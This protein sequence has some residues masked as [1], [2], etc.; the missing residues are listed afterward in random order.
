MNL[1]RTTVLLA[2]TVSTLACHDAG[3]PPVPPVTFTLDNING[4]SLPY[5]PA[6]PEAPTVIS[7]ALLLE[8]SGRATIIEHRRQMAVDVTDTR[9]YTYKINGN[10]IQ[11]D[12]SPP[13]P[14]NALCIAPPKGTITGSRVLLDM[15]GGN[16][17]PVYNFRLIASD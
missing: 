4:I 15:S 13:C 11:F 1:T 6:I 3:A 16:G 14:I 17:T 10:E 7:A 9:T 5:V 8:T 2:A 12:Y